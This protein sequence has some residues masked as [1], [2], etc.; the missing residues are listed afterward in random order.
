MPIIVGWALA[1][2]RFFSL[3]GQG[4]TYEE[5]RN[6]KLKIIPIPAFTDNY[7]WLIIAKDNKSSLCVDPG[8]AQPVKQYLK[9]HNLR[10]EAIL[11]T[12]HHHD[13]IGGVPELIA[14]N[15]FV[16][17][18]GPADPR[19]PVASLCSEKQFNFHQLQFEVINIPGHTSTHVCYVEK[20]LNLLFCG[21]TLFSAGCGR[22]FDGSLETLHQSLNLLKN[23]PK[24]T[25]VYCG[26]EYTRKNLRFASIVEPSNPDIKE[27]AENITT[28]LCSLPSTIALERKINPFFR[29]NEPEVINY[30]KKQGY[31]ANREDPFAVF[32]QLRADKDNF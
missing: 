20:Q 17:V 16:K 4:P 1:Q 32:K 28:V 9:D 15:P 25:K 10:L 7:I 5:E 31:P 14:A 8:D 2:Q 22:V 19:I 29:L 13:H 27:Y 12:H 3:L 23:L 24:E 11:L 26:H 30:V 21:D 18:Y 6:I